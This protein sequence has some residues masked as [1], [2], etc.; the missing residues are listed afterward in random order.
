MEMGQPTFDAKEVKAHSLFVGNF[1][2]N[3]QDRFLS[4][5]AA[6]I[7][8]GLMVYREDV[9]E[10][11]ERAPDAFSAMLSGGNFGKTLVQVSEDPT[12]Q[13]SEDPTA[14]GT[15]APAAFVTTGRR[16]G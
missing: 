11:L 14:S 5:M 8:D 16:K 1:V 4:E 15:E 2:E 12:N 13:V 3:Y 6:W 9:W 10:G 7:Q